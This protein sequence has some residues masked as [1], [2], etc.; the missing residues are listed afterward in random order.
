MS[1]IIFVHYT[2]VHLQEHNP[3]SR[4]GD[5]RADVF[6]K[7]QQI[8][9]IAREVKADFTTCGGDLFNPK[10]PEAIKHG[11]IT[12]L[13]TLYR[14]LDIPHYIV[15]GNHDL[16]KDRMDSLV[17][18][19]LGVLLSSGTLKQMT[20]QVVKKQDLSL[21]LNAYDF[22]EEPD[23]SERACP[24]PSEVDV[25]VLGIHLYA[26]PKGGT[27]YGG[28]KIFSYAELG[29]TGHNIYL[30]GHY[31]AD[32]G[33]VDQY[34]DEKQQTFVNIGSLTRGD[35]GDEN[36]KRNPKCC[37]VRI[38]K[39]KKTKKVSWSCE[40]RL[41]KVRPLEET[42]NLEKKERLAKQKEETK[43][44]VQKMQEAVQTDVK[45]D[46]DV[47]KH[48]KELVP[49]DIEVYNSVL[50]YITRGHEELGKIKGK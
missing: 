23:L 3:P 19:P 20:N 16:M 28:A 24:S 41:L 13:T 43:E 27:I 2:D 12:A 35:Y 45:S 22:D 7:L 10:K 39:D 32:N 46:G 4:L 9:D 47:A 25:Q 36:L 38:K 49:D 21:Q 48:L 33:V 14:S 44:L 11:T 50:E 31:H 40:E 42:F 1:E 18:Q 17:E 6:D 8:M 37:I 29:S 34:E 26:S 15:P 30:L 5:Y